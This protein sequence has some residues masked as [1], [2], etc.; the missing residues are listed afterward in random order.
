MKVEEILE[1]KLTPEE[2]K[3][4]DDA[5][6]RRLSIQQTADLID[7]HRKQQANK[8]KGLK[9]RAKDVK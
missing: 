2:E 1:T 4:T 9:R 7:A 6:K 3:I 8:K 5:I